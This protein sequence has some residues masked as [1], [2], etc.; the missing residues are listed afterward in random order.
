VAA[1]RGSSWY[2]IPTLPQAGCINAL[3]TGDPA[4]NIGFAMGTNVYFQGPNPNGTQ[5][6]DGYYHPTE[7]IL[8][9]WFMRLAPNNISEPTQS[10]STNIGRYSLL[11]DL[12][13]IPGFHQPATGCN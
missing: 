6:A 2:V 1:A 5:G 13:P 11:G 9:P 8:L 7:E 3:E 12:N 10:P 4:V